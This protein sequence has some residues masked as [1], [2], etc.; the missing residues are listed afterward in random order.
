MLAILCALRYV[1][2]S[3]FPQMIRWLYQKSNDNPN[4]DFFDLFQLMHYS[5]SAYNANH[6]FLAPLNIYNK[7]TPHLIS[8]KRFHYNMDNIKSSQW[9]VGL[10]KLI[11]SKTKIK[12][13]QKLRRF[14]KSNK[15]E[16][17]VKL[18]KKQP[19][20]KQSIFKSIFL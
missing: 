2:E 3:V 4:I 16:A 8:L 18:M 10:N 15:I 9:Q 1:E 7:S 12:N 11:V 17:A 19:I 20:K 6:A 13:V 5:Q 14:I